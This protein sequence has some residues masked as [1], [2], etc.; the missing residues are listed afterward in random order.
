MLYGL[1]Y[2]VQK[3]PATST[4]LENDLD[5]VLVHAKGILEMGGNVVGIDRGNEP[6][7]DEAQIKAKIGWKDV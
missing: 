5:K 6:F 1:R 2:R 4:F 3:E 7:L